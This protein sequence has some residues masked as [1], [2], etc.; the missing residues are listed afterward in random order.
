MW[1]PLSLLQQQATRFSS[2]RKIATYEKIMTAVIKEHSG[3]VAQT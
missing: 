3:K 1:D 2:F